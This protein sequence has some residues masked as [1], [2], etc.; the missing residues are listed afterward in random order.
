MKDIFRN[1][2]CIG[3]KLKR[4]GVRRICVKKMLREFEKD[5]EKPFRASLPRKTLY[6]HF[7]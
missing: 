1:L 4:L 6:F 7:I 3:C 2:K 5:L